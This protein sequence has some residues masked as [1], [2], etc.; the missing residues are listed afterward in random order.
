MI[1]KILN[2]LNRIGA[3]IGMSYPHNQYTLQE[4]FGCPEV[5]PQN[6][7]TFLE[8]NVHKEF[9][10]ALSGC[11][12]I[13]VYGE[14]RQGKTWTIEKY[15]NSQIRIG[16]NSA[17]DIKQIK[18]DM[19][20]SVNMAVCEVEHSVTEEYSAGSNLYT[21]IGSQLI[22]HAGGSTST[23][24]A[25]KETIKTTYPTVNVEYTEEFMRAL[26]EKSKGK[27]FVL[28]N[29]HY[30]TPKV[31]QQFCSLLKEFNYRG[32]NVIIVGVWKESSK[33]TALAPD[34]VNRCAHIDIGSWSNEELH[35][36]TRLGTNAL[37]ISIDPRCEELF[38]RCCANNIGIYKDFLMKF[39][40]RCEVRG[41]QSNQARL[42]S[43]DIATETVEA[44]IKE[45]FSPLHDR[46]KNLA[47]PQ[48]ER[49]DSKHVRQK[50]I[51]SILRLIL[52]E[53][54]ASIQ[55]GIKAEKIQEE[56]DRICDSNGEEHIQSSN[57]TQELGNLHI[58]E[59][60]RQTGQNFI[61]LFYFDKPNRKIL[62]IEPTIYVL[63]EYN[64]SLLQNILDEVS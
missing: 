61:P 64:S 54:S 38:I 63:K 37:N 32:I 50:I 20:Q 28:D 10:N 47:T 59:E 58:R 62:V 57:I 52:Q 5:P 26:T 29:F 11:H 31:Q 36:V 6:C 53:D 56:V 23:A 49:K 14:S 15:C 17:M 25:H 16:C 8:R 21:E 45:V 30:L 27:Y 22:A 55:R 46:I 34:L 40:Q 4:V 33:I 44:V 12:I 51:A 3:K 39:C 7:P 2:F 1:P 41:T 24:V 19:L 48:R 60:N 35:K 42:D 18:T 13:V 9:Q 43:Y